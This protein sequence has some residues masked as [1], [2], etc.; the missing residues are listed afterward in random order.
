[1]PAY[2]DANGVVVNLDNWP[3]VSYKATV[4]N[5]AYANSQF[6][7]VAVPA[8]GINLI[9]FRCFWCGKYIGS[10]GVEGDHVAPQSLGNSKTPELQGLFQDAQEALNPDGTPWNLVLSCSECNGGSRNKSKMMLRSSFSQDRDKQGPKG[11]GGGGSSMV[12]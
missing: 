1:M 5:N 11:G 10:A 3:G 6:W 2:T 8:L 4:I 7:V 9:L 12:A